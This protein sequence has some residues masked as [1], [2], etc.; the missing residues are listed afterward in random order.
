MH[1]TFPKN[2]ADGLIFE[3]IP[4]TFYQFDKSTSSWIR[5]DGFDAIGLA[6]Q[7]E[8]G[9]M[10]S[11]DFR[12]LNGLI[13]PPPRIAIKPEDCEVRLDVGTI[14]MK[15]LDDF[16]TV[17]GTIDLITKDGTTR[18][19]WQ[20]VNDVWGFDFRVDL[21]ALLKEVEKR[22]N[23]SFRKRLGEQGEKGEKGDPGT[24]RLETGPVGP[25]GESGVN[26]PFNGQASFDAVESVLT[27]DNNRAIVDVQA[28]ETEDEGKLVVTRA[29][30]GNPLAC[31]SEVVPKQVMSPWIVAINDNPEKLRFDKKKAVDGDCSSACQICA[32]LHFLYVEPILSAV[33]ERFETLVL[34]LKQQKE[35]VVNTWLQTMVKV[36]NE[37][38]AA[39]CCATE[40]AKTRIRNARAR[41]RIEEQRIQAAQADFNVVVDGQEDKIRVDMDRDKNCPVVG[42]AATTNGQT[43]DSCSVEFVID[44]TVNISPDTAVSAELP[45]GTYTAEITDCCVNKKVDGRFTGR[46]SIRHSIP[47]SVPPG[48]LDEGLGLPTDT[49]IVA[50]PDLGEYD[51]NAS[52]RAAYLSLTTTICHAGGKIKAWLEDTFGL[53]NAGEITICLKPARCYDAPTTTG[54]DDVGLTDAVNVYVGD[55][56][57]PKNLVGAALPFVGSKTAVENYSYGVGPSGP[58]SV[59]HADLDC[60]DFGANITFGPTPA[61][62]ELRI[63]FY[64][65][66][67]GLVMFFTLNKKTSAFTQHN[68][69]AGITV[70]QNSTPTSVIVSDDAGQLSGSSNTFAANWTTAGIEFGGHGDGGVIG[71]LDKINPVWKIKVKFPQLGNIREIKY[72]SSDGSVVSLAHTTLAAGLQDSVKDKTFI[73]SPNGPS[74]FMPASQVEWYIRGLRIEACCAAIVEFMG[75]PWAVIKRSIGPNGPCGGGETLNTACI[76]SFLS[77][78]H[79]S[80]AWPIL[81]P[82]REAIGLPTSGTVEFEEDSELESIFLTKI[83]AG[84]VLDSVGDLNEHVVVLFPQI[85]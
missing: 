53:D 71:Y 10:D 48:N 67:D 63:F 58:C 30:V 5:L 66:T 73:F 77:K 24:D 46:A 75:T 54:P 84:D 80:I 64:D 33:R 72:V 27:G 85:F 70:E 38:K 31:P 68:V 20:I 17:E 21:D 28:V 51:S 69:Q 74:C 42:G 44:G 45:A 3:I 39:I 60:D 7:S 18:E 78:G 14:E 15:S 83:R 16:L 35:A 36:F 56:P 29:N 32:G 50:F 76:S 4:G 49:K 19:P 2:P 6:T 9:L 41:E 55:E 23:L 82:S 65:G 59:P 62:N 26:T 47:I 13:V 37:Q 57:D 12:K 1:V 52:A 8:D 81:L 34:E 79:P 22:G 43:C 61:E 25:Q 11:I 40:N